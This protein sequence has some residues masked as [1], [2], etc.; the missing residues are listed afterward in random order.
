MIEIDTCDR[1]KSKD[2][3][4]TILLLQWKTVNDSANTQKHLQ[5]FSTNEV[6][7]Q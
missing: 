1:S 3:G 4:T 7:Y 6:E 2:D 5:F